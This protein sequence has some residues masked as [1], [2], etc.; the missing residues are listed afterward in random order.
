MSLENEKLL[1]TVP[2]GS[3]SVAPPRSAPVNGSQKPTPGATTSP[4]WMSP[5]ATASVPTG[6]G[7]ANPS[8]ECGSAVPTCCSSAARFH[9]VIVPSAVATT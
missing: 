4:Y 8:G 5:R 2:G 6:V 9:N 7:P 3:S 1:G